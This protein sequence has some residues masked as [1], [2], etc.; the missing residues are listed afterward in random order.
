VYSGSQ[1]LLSLLVS[2]QD[3]RQAQYSG[4]QFGGLWLQLAVHQ[5]SEA[6]GET[7]SHTGSL[8]CEIVLVVDVVCADGRQAQYS[9]GQ[10]GGLWL[11]LAVHQKSEALGETDSHTSSLDCDV[12]VVVDGI[13]A[14]GRQAQ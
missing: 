11:Q 4:G 5:E 1:S 2:P 8:D 14:G 13:G 3:G 6:L 10:F 12:V 7:D 9:G